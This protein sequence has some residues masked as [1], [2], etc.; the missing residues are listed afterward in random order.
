MT[1]RIGKQRYGT[2]NIV[3][4]LSNG[5]VEQKVTQ[6]QIADVTGWSREAVRNYELGSRAAP[7][8]YVVAL[9]DVL[10]YELVL[11][12]KER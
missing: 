1:I 2:H 11:M 5:R 6:Q 12:K 4:Y 9:A 7:F 8:D 10:G 3:T